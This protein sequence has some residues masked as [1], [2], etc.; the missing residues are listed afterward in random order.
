MRTNY[1][2]ACRGS[3]LSLCQANLF[4]STVKNN[5]PECAFQLN[6]IRTRGDIMTHVPLETLDGKD[7]FTFEIQQALE[8][9]EADFAVHSMKD[10]SH[11]SF[12]KN[13]SYA[14]FD[15]DVLQDVV[16]FNPDIEHRLKENKPIRIGTSSPRR[17]ALG[18][19]FL[20]KGLPRFQANGP[21]LEA[22]SIRGN[23]DNRLE[24]LN[25]GKFDG[26]ILAMAGL[27]RVISHS[28]TGE[29]I[30]KMLS[31]R[32]IML[33]PLFECPPA[34]NQGALIAEAHENNDDAMQIL[35]SINQEDLLR[36]ANQEREIMTQYGHPDC[37]QRFGV[38]S[39]NHKENEFSYASGWDS[40]NQYFQYWNYEKP[41]ALLPQEVLFF[42][43]LRKDAFSYHNLTETSDEFKQPICMVSNYR[44]IHSKISIERLREK[45]IWTAGV[46]TWTKLAKLGLWVEGCADG[47]GLDTL[48]NIWNK[49]LFDYHWEDALLFTNESSSLHYSK[50]E[51][52]LTTTY[53][54]KPTPTKKI[55]DKLQSAKAVFWTSYQQFKH[56]HGFT[57]YDCH[58][59]CA[60][61]KTA[62]LIKSHD[63]N[64]FLFP[65]INSFK[66]WKNI[67]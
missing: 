53:R 12:F 24:Q 44:A 46:S 19:R 25:D 65:T 51:T 66:A 8:K 58:H 15:R 10:I 39:V 38:F 56:Y 55:Q 4:I 5:H 40:N 7:F 37:A 30:R 27:N 49:S 20:E 41:R 43:E 52:Q 31:T 33:L 63:I 29:H 17:A 3:K 35:K 32:R 64:P 14:V 13:N 6:I 2:V 23:V 60:S 42:Q 45:S 18:L 9:G 67:E 36:Q 11:L 1:I 57:R 47:M 34:A 59:L 16:I 22:S 26:I 48:K 21:I 28:D 61:G 50:D 54:L 62:D